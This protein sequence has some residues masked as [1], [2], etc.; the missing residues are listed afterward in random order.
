MSRSVIYRNEA[1]AGERGLVESHGMTNGV[2]LCTS[3]NVS[4]ETREECVECVAMDD[5]QSASVY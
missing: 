3:N 4:R 5:K 2:R 1:V